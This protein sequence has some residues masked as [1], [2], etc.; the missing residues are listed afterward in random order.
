MGDIIF[1]IICLANSHNID[2]DKV[3][4]K[5]MDKLTGRDKD[6]FERKESVLS[7]ESDYLSKT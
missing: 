4:K 1:A 6:R 7:S 5:H 3:W 2:L